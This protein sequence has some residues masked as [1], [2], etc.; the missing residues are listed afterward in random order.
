MA[1]CT[2]RPNKSVKT[3]ALVRPLAMLAGG[4]VAA[5]LRH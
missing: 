4:L 2:P 5:Y 3:D 1:L